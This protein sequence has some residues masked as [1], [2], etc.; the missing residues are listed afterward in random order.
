MVYKCAAFD[1]LTFKLIDIE[2]LNNSIFLSVE[3]VTK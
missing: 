1:L 2:F 3:V